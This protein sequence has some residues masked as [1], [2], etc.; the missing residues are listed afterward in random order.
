LR[1]V[2]DR[3]AGGMKCGIWNRLQTGIEKMGVG[4]W[5]IEKIEYGA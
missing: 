2:K 4:R 3:K 5:G 1:K